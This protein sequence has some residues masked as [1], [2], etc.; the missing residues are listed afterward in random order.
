MAPLKT[1]EVG[2]LL[3]N[4]TPGEGRKPESTQ[5]RETA[6]QSEIATSRKQ[7]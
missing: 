3:G 5:G 2:N 4:T 1:S 7:P 6:A